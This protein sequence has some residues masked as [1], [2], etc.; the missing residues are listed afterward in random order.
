MLVAGCCAWPAGTEALVVAVAGG[1]KRAEPG[2]N[3]HQQLSLLSTMHAFCPFSACSR[4]FA[5][6]GA[7]K[8]IIRS[9]VVSFVPSFVA[10]FARPAGKK[11]VRNRLKA[12]TDAGLGSTSAWILLK[13]LGAR[14]D[15]GCVGVGGQQGDEEEWRRGVDHHH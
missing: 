7:T 11:S 8:A 14:G 5:Q 12:S 15:W 10:M 6:V 1:Q 13:G 3:R 2:R 9:S 4:L